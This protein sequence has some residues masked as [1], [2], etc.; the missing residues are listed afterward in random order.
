MLLICFK[1][2]STWFNIEVDCVS[3]HVELM[4]FNILNASFYIAEEQI[5]LLSLISQLQKRH[6]QT[7]ER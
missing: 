5:W 1:Y 2:D 3:L 7:V 4:L 6:F